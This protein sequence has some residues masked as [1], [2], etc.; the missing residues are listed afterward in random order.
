MKIRSGFVSNSST[1]SFIIIGIKVLSKQIRDLL[2]N[3]ESVLDESPGEVGEVI[4]RLF[5]TK[6]DIV[7]VDKYSGDCFVMGKQFVSI[8]EESLHEI[9]FPKRDIKPEICEDINKLSFLDKELTVDDLKIYGK[10]EDNH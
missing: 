3:E 2:G 7:Q 5:G 6:L 9:K 4:N 1:S 10:A 8:S